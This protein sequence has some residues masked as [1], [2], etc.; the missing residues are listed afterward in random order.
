VKRLPTKKVE[1]EIL[2]PVGMG[3]TFATG[4]KTAISCYEFETSK[5][6]TISAEVDYAP[7]KNL[8]NL[9]LEES[10][11]I[12][13]KLLMK[14]DEEMKK[15][16]NTGS[17]IQWAWKVVYNPPKYPDGFDSIVVTM[18]GKTYTFPGVY[19]KEERTRYLER[20]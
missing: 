3:T 7:Q 1:D 10:E 11:K 18:S 5:P 14:R 13:E 8:I 9:S 15:Y 20:I 16:N 6:L 4:T 17:L 12:V 19:G 2:C